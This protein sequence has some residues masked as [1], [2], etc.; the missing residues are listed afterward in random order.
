MR[1]IQYIEEIKKIAGKSGKGVVRG[2]G[3]DCAVLKY[4]KGE[5]LLWSTD[6]LIEGTHFSLANAGYKDIGRKAAAVNVSDI[7]AMGG[8]PE[9]IT[10]SLGLPGK[11]SSVNI[12]DL[13]KGI[14][15]I[16][17]KYG[18]EIVGGDING[19]K[20]LTVDISI[21]GTVARDKMVSRSG[22]G[23]GD[24]ILITGPIR[25]GKKEHLTFSPR[26]DE[27]SFLVSKYKP[28]AMIDV[29]DGISTDILRI[30]GQSSVGCRI[31][32]QF[33]PLSKGLTSD[34]ALYYGESF[35]ILFTMSRA[36]AEKLR[37]DMLSGK[38]KYK[39]YDIG[40]IVDRSMGA[41][42]IRNDG[43]PVILRSDGYKHV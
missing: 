3:D 19:S 42:L 32:E 23:K 17:S 24:R 40:E 25:D 16:A 7:A 29:S 31:H 4:R 1:E 26:L 2:I 18:I 35:E 10:V 34:E 38:I 5:Y 36:K 9:Y 33:L 28:N 13:Y 11:T 22:A 21:I 37:S 14:K 8:D 41:K 27:S 20:L 30:C 43:R 15:S 12:K 39:Y 6:M